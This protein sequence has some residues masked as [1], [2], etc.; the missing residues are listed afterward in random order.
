MIL[1]SNK[2]ICQCRLIDRREETL[3]VLDRFVSDEKSQTW[4]GVF[5]A[6]LDGDALVQRSVHVQRRR[7]ANRREH[8]RATSRPTATS[9]SHVFQVSAQK[10]AL[11]ALAQPVSRVVEQW[12]ASQAAD[13]LVCQQL[14][15][16]HVSAAVGLDALARC[17]PAERARDDNSESDPRRGRQQRRRSGQ[18]GV[19]QRARLPLLAR[20]QLRQGL[21]ERQRRVRIAL[22]SPPLRVPARLGSVP[23][24]ER[25]QVPA[26]AAGQVHAR[27]QTSAR[28]P[29]LHSA[30]RLGHVLLR[31]LS[32]AAQPVR[33]VLV[34]RLCLLHLSRCA[35]AT[36]L[37]GQIQVR[38]IL[39]SN[40]VN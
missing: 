17:L 26:S 34:W 39:C 16:E 36:M 12:R 18:V 1:F 15:F 4:R 2:A 11:R 21:L 13:E 40:K 23:R 27:A 5:R 38:S 30:G 9:Q 20:A 29:R 22:H 31:L 24:R 14:V 35:I 3:V 37:F 10:P 6:R 32:A 8:C 19:E 25:V 33:R 28:A 7:A